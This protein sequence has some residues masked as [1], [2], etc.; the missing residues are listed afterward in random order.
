MTDPLTPDEKQY[1]FL[2]A[3]TPGHTGLVGADETSA[4]AGPQDRESVR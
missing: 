3:D 4:V 2:V 1:A